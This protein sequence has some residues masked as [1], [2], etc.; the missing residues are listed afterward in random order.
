M[1]GNSPG[2]QRRVSIALELASTR[3]SGTIKT[4]QRA[5]EFSLA[6]PTRRVGSH[7]LSKRASPVNLALTQAATFAPL[8]CQCIY[9]ANQTM[10]C[11]CKRNEHPHHH[12][13]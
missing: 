9:C 5:G 7:G 8:P 6:E 3:S 13:H 10:R 12:E 2:L 1:S 4:P 11:P